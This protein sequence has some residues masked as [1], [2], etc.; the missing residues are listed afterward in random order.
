MPYDTAQGRKKSEK[1]SRPV[2]NGHDLYGKSQGSSYIRSKVLLPLLQSRGRES[3]KK[4]KKKQFEKP[5]DKGETFNIG[6]V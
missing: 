3:S 4:V 1:K 2:D 6:Y 5:H